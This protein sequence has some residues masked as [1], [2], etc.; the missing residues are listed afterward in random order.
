MLW[1][2]KTI[3]NLI[4]TFFVA[5]RTLCSEYLGRS[6]MVSLALKSLV[7]QYSVSVWFY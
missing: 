2:S 1:R 6:E 3:E 5:H 4:H 7:Y